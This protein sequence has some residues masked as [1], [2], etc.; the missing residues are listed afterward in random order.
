M[1]SVKYDSSKS[2]LEQE[3]ET[4]KAIINLIEEHEPTMSQRATGK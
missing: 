4:K 3:E 1:K 2:L